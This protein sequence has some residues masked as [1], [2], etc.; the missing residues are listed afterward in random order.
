MLTSTAAQ[1]RDS[2]VKLTIPSHSAESCAVIPAGDLRAVSTADESEMFTEHLRHIV[3]ERLKMSLFNFFHYTPQNDK[4]LKEITEEIAE[5]GSASLEFILKR[6]R[7]KD[8]DCGPQPSGWLICQ[9]CINGDGQQC[10]RLSGIRSFLKEMTKDQLG[11]TWKLFKLVFSD[12][13]CTLY[14]SMDLSEEQSLTPPWGVLGL[15]YS[16]RNC[17][18]TKNNYSNHHALGKLAE[19]LVEKGMLAAA[20]EDDHRDHGGAGQQSHPV[21]ARSE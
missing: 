13:V 8:E 7:D 17:S 10:I 20:G 16:L 12:S 4:Q 3:Y 19:R 18:F 9:P 21:D 2:S 1:A 11:N 14:N 6:W 15:G 5:N